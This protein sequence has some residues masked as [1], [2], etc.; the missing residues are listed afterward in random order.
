MSFRRNLAYGKTAESAITL[1]FRRRGWAV[2]PVY[3]KL[4][5]EGKG[6]QV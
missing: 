2:M 3:E 1:W 6:P 4:I 5:D